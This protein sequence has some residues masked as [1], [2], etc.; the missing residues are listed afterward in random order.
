M[1][2]HDPKGPGNGGGP[3]PP[4]PPGEFKPAEYLRAVKAHLKSGRQKSAYSVLLEAVVRYPKDPLILSFY[5]CLQAVVDKKYQRGV[6]T[7][8]KAIN[9]FQTKETFGEEALYFPV[10]YLN[11]G[12][13]YLAGGK[14]KSAVDA[15]TKGLKYDNSH[16][17]LKREL[18]GLG[19]RK[20]P[21]LPFLGRSNPINKYIG[22]LLHKSSK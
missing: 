16:P 19:I 17:D 11:L 21:P 3:A 14:K 7:C 8:K 2:D 15:F 6:D 12:R 10:F 13:A 4:E 18:R 5:G 1:K 20:R 9:L 22:M